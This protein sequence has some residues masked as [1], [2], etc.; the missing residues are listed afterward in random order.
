MSFILA[1][2]ACERYGT[3]ILRTRQ[4]RSWGGVNG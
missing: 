3:A 2:Y 4:G 1:A